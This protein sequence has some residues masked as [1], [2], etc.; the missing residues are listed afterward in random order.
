[1]F[2]SPCRPRPR[3]FGFLGSCSCCVLCRLLS[4]LRESPVRAP[5]ALPA[6]PKCNAHPLPDPPFHEP[7][8]PHAP[9]C[10]PITQSGRL[11]ACQKRRAS[12]QQAVTQP[13][14]GRAARPWQG[15]QRA[16]RR[17]VAAHLNGG[18]AGVSFL[19]GADASRRRG[20]MATVQMHGDGA[21][22]WRR[23]GCMATV[24]MTGDGADA[25]RACNSGF[26]RAVR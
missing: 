9:P 17:S 15:A 10:N 22:A 13:A 8:P 2:G 14:P 19:N 4:M 26:G 20:C 3:A 1:V 16:P 23:C 11:T 7:S 24:R 5:P 12:C 18:S 21:D 25:W 6:Q